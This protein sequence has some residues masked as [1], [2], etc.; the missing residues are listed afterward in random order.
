MVENGNIQV[1]IVED[2]EEI[3]ALLVLLIGRSPGFHCSQSYSSCEEIPDNLVDNPPD[4]VLMDV[5]L[6]GINGI[7]GVKKLISKLHDTNFIMLTI[8]DDDETVFDALSA[9]ASGYL[10]KDTPP[11]KLLAGIREVVEGGAPMTPA[12]ARKVTASFQT[13]GK[14]PLSDRETEIL[15]LLC[16]GHHYGAVAEALFVSGHTVRAHIKNIY[17]KLQVN[18]RAEAVS[19]AI[20]DRLL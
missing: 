10:L 3:R 6:P 9:G 16:A 14:S 15:Q 19:K 8:R 5:E 4:V 18:S 20:K 12:I 11:V 17:R 13:T 2:D 7:E 1:A